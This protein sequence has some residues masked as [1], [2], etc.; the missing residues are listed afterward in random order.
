MRRDKREIP[1]VT[2]PTERVEFYV[3]SFTQNHI[4]CSLG[5]SFGSTRHVRLV[6]SMRPI[7][8]V[9]VNPFE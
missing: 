5:Q 9:G 2:L 8:D 6:S 1:G 3:F 4:S 7:D